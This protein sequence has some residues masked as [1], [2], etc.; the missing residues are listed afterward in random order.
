MINHWEAPIHSLNSQ[1]YVVKH[2]G[3]REKPALMASIILILMAELV[4]LLLLTYGSLGHWILD[5][6]AL[7]PLPLK[8]YPPDKLNNVRLR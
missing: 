8:K 3:V 7:V 6:L 2:H 5:F 1:S 4:I